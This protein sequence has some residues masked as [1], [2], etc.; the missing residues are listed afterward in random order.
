MEI[1]ELLGEDL[2]AIAAIGGGPAWKPDHAVW[3]GLLADHR[4]GRRVVLVARDQ[5]KIL[6]YGT[7]LWRSRYPPFRIA[8]TPEINSLVVIEQARHRG[9]ATR[10]IGE[11]ERRARAAGRTTIGLAVGLHAEY[12]PAQRLYVKLGYCP[13]GKGVTYLDQPVPPGTTVS[14]DDDLLLWLRKPL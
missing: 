6:A 11:F 1:T 4:A 5:R 13:D 12:G 8:G 9:I 14:L 2:E 3:A 10:M 7:L